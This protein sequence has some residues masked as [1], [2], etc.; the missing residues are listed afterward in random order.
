M[1]L[2]VFAPGGTAQQPVTISGYEE[3]DEYTNDLYE[4]TNGRGHLGIGHGVGTASNRFTLTDYVYNREEELPDRIR[5]QPGQSRLLPAVP[6]GRAAPVHEERAKGVRHWESTTQRSTSPSVAAFVSSPHP[7]SIDRH[8]STSKA[9]LVSYPPAASLAVPLMQ[10]RANAT[11]RG[12]DTRYSPPVSLAQNQQICPS[13][14][15]AIKRLPPIPTSP[16]AQH[17]QTPIALAS[18]SVS[19]N[20]PPTLSATLSSTSIASSQPSPLLPPFQLNPAKLNGSRP[21]LITMPSNASASGSTI[22]FRVH[23]AVEG[24]PTGLAVLPSLS[25]LSFS[26]M[27]RNRSVSFVGLEEAQ[28]EKG[29]LGDVGEKE[30]IAVRVMAP[31]PE[32]E[33]KKKSRWWDWVSPHPRLALSSQIFPDSLFCRLLLGTVIFELIVDLVIE[34]SYLC[35]LVRWTF[36]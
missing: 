12:N 16:P 7:S 20:P 34:V 18:S 35:C 24:Q 17:P 9:T 4:S 10:A 23:E 19:P 32:R 28:S 22:A 36:D 31:R 2:S 3:L 15:T 13:D 27:E 11:V 29:R 33:M 26:E 30:G 14:N 5:A 21:S 8:T 6:A 1:S 25:S